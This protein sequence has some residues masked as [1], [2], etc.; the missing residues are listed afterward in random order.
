MAQQRPSAAGG[1][2]RTQY[3]CNQASASELAI[4]CANGQSP[5]E[6]VRNSVTVKHLCDIRNPRE[7]HFFRGRK[8]HIFQCLMWPLK[9][10]LSRM[11]REEKIIPTVK[12]S[13]NLFEKISFGKLKAKGGRGRAAQTNALSR[14]TYNVRLSSP[15]GLIFA[16]CD[17][18][19]EALPA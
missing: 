14:R 11:I 8:N 3:S 13:K 6:Q 12:N 2:L 10:P 17:V 9:S 4:P 5:A 15:E 16:R 7:A 19:G 18:A 1:T